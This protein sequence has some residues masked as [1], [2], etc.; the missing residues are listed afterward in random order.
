MNSGERELYSE[1]RK[2]EL[3]ILQGTTV[4]AFGHDAV[5]NTCGVSV[6]KV[7]RGVAF[8]NTTLL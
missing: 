2:P 7:T 1:N 8:D 3:I 4:T 5:G 6:L